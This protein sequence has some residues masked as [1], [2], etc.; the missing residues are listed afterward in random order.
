MGATAF[1]TASISPVQILGVDGQTPAA[2]DNPL[3]VE[4][5]TGSVNITAVI[6]GAV[7]LAASTA[8]IGSATI[9]GSLPSGNNP[10]GKINFNA[11]TA[12]LSSVSLNFSALGTSV[13]VT[14]VATTTIRVFKLLLSNS[15]AVLLTFQDNATALTGPLSLGTNGSIVLDFDGEPWFSASNATNFNIQLSTTSQISG[16]L[17]YTQV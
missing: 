6:S 15:T 9:I 10:L 3:P 2:I 14:G 1:N 5:A 13:I 16:R 4:L 7:T 8:S 12:A 17:Y 11:T